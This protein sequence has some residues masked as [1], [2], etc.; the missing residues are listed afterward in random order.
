[1]RP[2]TERKVLPSSARIAIKTAQPADW[3][4]S[5]CGTREGRHSIEVGRQSGGRDSDLVRSCCLSAAM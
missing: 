3:Q 1:M 2:C 5:E 4:P